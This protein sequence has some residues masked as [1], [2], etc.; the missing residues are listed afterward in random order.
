MQNDEIVNLTKQDWPIENQQVLRHCILRAN[1]SMFGF[2]EEYPAQERISTIRGILKW[3]LV[4]YHLAWA[5]S[6]EIFDGIT[7]GWEKYMGSKILQLT[8]KNSCVIAKHVWEADDDPIDSDQ[9]FRKAN[10]EKN[11]LLL[12]GFDEQVSHDGK[13][14]IVLVHGGFGE[15]AFAFLR[16]YF[17][18][19]APIQITENIML[20]PDLDSATAEE[21]V[22][23]PMPELKPS[24]VEKAGEVLPVEPLV[25]LKNV[26]SQS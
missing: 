23:D 13:T 17:N 26:H 15:N 5:A 18:D 20:L 6:K 1:E 24:I 7:A 10:R 21:F 22:A 19:A 11:Q 12:S 4:D 25:K 14:R 9:S 8:G 3:D 16:I 2:L